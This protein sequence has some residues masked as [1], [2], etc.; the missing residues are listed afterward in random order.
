MVNSLRVILVIFMF[1]YWNFPV[2]LTT[3]PA[4]VN[5]IIYNGLPILYLLRH[6]FELLVL[7]K[8]ASQYTYC[9][10][11]IFLIAIIVSWSLVVLAYNDSNDYSYFG[12]F[13][14]VI[15]CIYVD[16][17]LLLISRGIFEQKDSISSFCWFWGAS[18]TF[19]VL[20]TIISL[21]FPG[22][23]ADWQSLV[24]YTASSEDFMDTAMY[25]TRFSIGGFA[26]YGQ[27]IVCSLGVVF[28]IILM[29][30]GYKIGILFLLSSL[31]GNLFYGRFGVIL[32]CFAIV[33]FALRTISIKKIGVYLISVLAMCIIFDIFFEMLDNPLLDAWK[34]WLMQPI[35]AFITG[36]EFGQITFG[37]SG[38]KLAYDMYW[39]PGIDTLIFGD[40]R[41]TNVLGDYYMHTDAGYMR[42]VLYFG[43][44]GALFV[45]ALYVV[46][47]LWERQ[48]NKYDALSRYMGEIVF[49]F[50]F[51]EEYKGDGY[52]LFFGV[53]VVGILC[54]LIGEGK[55]NA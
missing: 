35:E 43:F 23:R 18:L 41:Y 34:L 12:K 42:I 1:A 4:W 21:L 10:Y 2:Y 31:L 24:A 33:F 45:Y 32:S 3:V 8:K 13:F 6:R 51:L 16:V 26:G 15:R 22:F 44:I 30:K 27:T 53:M 55:G 36:V 39:L 37:S 49:T 38:D 29:S 50:L 19:C 7:I 46:L 54:G 5:Q 14:V 48:V 11:V 17:F 9:I 47:F 25:I 40:G 28:S 52:Q 20:F